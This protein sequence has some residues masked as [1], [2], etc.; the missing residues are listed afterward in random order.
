MNNKIWMVF[1]ILLIV[2]CTGGLQAHKRH[3]RDSNQPAES[4]SNEQL[5][6]SANNKTQ[7]TLPSPISQERETSSS[8]QETELLPPLR[9]LVFQHIHNKLVHFPIAFGLAAALFII[10]GLKK[11]GYE[12]STK[13]LLFLG[14]LFAIA[15]YFSGRA[16]KDAFEDTPLEQVLKIHEILGISTGISLWLGFLMMNLKPTK[17]YAWIIALII[18]GLVSAVGFY[19]GILAHT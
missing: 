12:N 4:S 10:I 16:Q 1:V 6:G 17:K 5:V 11:P 7:D 15:A 8:D 18:I 9:E 3:S 19:G 14:G 13:I 2:F